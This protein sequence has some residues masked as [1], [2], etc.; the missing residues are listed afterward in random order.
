[1]VRIYWQNCHYQTWP[2]MFQPSQSIRKRANKVLWRKYP[3]F[4]FVQ[5]ILC[6]NLS[7]VSIN[8]KQSMYLILLLLQNLLTLSLPKQLA[9]FC[10]HIVTS[11]ANFHE[12]NFLECHTYV[13]N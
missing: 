8:R 7:K 4:K 2:M 9:S 5:S 13:K 12:A 6:S 10:S 3:L 11:V 1:M